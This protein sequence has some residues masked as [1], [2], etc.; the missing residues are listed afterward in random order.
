MTIDAS[1]TNDFKDALIAGNRKACS[2]IINK[3]LEDQVPVTDIYEQVIKQ[4]LY[5]IGDNW[6][7]GN[8]S[9]GTE[10]LAS[11]MVEGILNDLFSLIIS[12]KKSGQ[13]AVFA[14]VENERHQIGLKMISD[15]FEM[16]GWNTFYL[17]SDVPVDDLIWYL[18]EK[19]PDI[20]ALS[21][22]MTNNVQN[23]EKA[24]QKIRVVFPDQLILIGGQGLR[25]GAGELIQDHFKI[26]YIPDLYI[27]D[28]FFA[29]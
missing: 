16:N 14:C 22:T 18:R 19:K 24:L 8:I 28:Q 2:T 26:R 15:V 17:G 11:A 4:A 9:I 27:L 10:H 21:I 6:K 20:L 12:R 23:L 7:T 3:L 5:G 1:D 25:K 13:S 29:N